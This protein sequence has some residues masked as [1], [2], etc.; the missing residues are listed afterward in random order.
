M[1]A[2][3]RSLL[4]TVFALAGPQVGHASA[5]SGVH[6]F[7]R[8]AT[9]TV[10]KA[11]GHGT[12][13]PD[14]IVVTRRAG[15]TVDGR[16]GD[17]VVCGGPGPDRLRGGPGDDRI[18]GRGGRDRLSGGLGR[19]RFAAGRVD[20]VTDRQAGDVVNGR[21]VPDIVRPKPRTVVIAPS[22][23]RTVVGAGDAGVVA[24]VLSHGARAPRRGATLVVPIGSGAPRGV[25]GRVVAVSRSGRDTVVR[26]RSASLSEAYAQFSVRRTG[27]LGELARRGA[28]GSAATRFDCS[29]DARPTLDAEVDVSRL[30]FEAEYDLQTRM[31]RVVLT[32]TPEVSLSA[33]F[34]GKLR[35]TARKAAGVLFI[36]V[37]GPLGVEVSPAITIEADGSIAAN[38]RW[39]PRIVYGFMTSR[40]T[41]TEQYRSFNKGAFDLDLSGEAGLR[42]FLGV[43]LH[44]SVA[45]R[46]GIGGTLGPTLTARAEADSAGRRCLTVDG[47]IRAELTAAA[48]VFFSDWKFTL[49][50]ATFG[51]TRVWERCDAATPV[52]RARGRAIWGHSIGAG[53]ASLLAPE[54]DVPARTAG[55]GRGTGIGLWTI[56]D[57]GAAARV[58]RP[59][60]TD[61]MQPRYATQLSGVRALAGDESTLYALRTDGTVWAQGDG[62]SGQLGDGT[63]GD[64][65]HSPSLVRVG[66]LASI[67][68]I[69]GEGGNGYALDASGTVWGWGEVYPGMLPGI[70]P[71]G[72][73]VVASPRPIPGMTDVVSIDLNGQGVLAV[74]RDGSVW[75]WGC[76]PYALAGDGTG[77]AV[78]SGPTRVPGLPGV[79]KV[80]GG[81]GTAFAIDAAGGVWAWGWNG[82][83]YAGTGIAA[84]YLLSPVRVPHLTG[85]RAIVPK[86]ALRHDGRVYHWGDSGAPQLA[87]QPRRGIALSVGPLLLAE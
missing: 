20:R 4:L 86:A 60:E 54:L 9:V 6:C 80:D 11:V 74:K 87:D 66:G 77:N 55:I 5:A 52:P 73:G 24:V 72:P 1:V 21:R 32:G 18:A 10:S 85:I 53:G 2:A 15:A 56:A 78:L 31:L 84:S 41:G 57:D 7:G 83:N 64:G 22:A 26:L 76:P 63:A 44:A 43:N 58:R 39:R 36:P 23:V 71:T 51:T 48:D 37:A 8:R 27:T 30:Q 49:A 62:A 61:E 14:V 69:D 47:A 79:V 82:N 28:S 42:A 12:R 68:E 45:G 46:V 25:L 13:G 3:L 65:R 67:V 17:D 35:C 33:G 19:D 40:S 16:G 81:Y 75:I 38:L 29:G 50:G 59:F 34:S 70:M